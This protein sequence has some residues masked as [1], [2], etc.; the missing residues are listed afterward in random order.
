MFWKGK[1]P[2]SNIQSK[3]RDFRYQLLMKACK[4]NKIK[5]LFLGHHKDD[6]Y[7]NFFIRLI[8]G[9]GLKGLVSLAKGD[10]KLSKDFVILRPL[11]NIEKK[12]LKYISKKVF[13]YYIE[14]PSNKNLDFQRIRLRKLIKEFH[15]EGLNL[16][17]LNL[18]IKN[19]NSANLSIESIVNNNIESN[20]KFINNKCILN[21]NFFCEGNEI[22][23]RS[24]SEVLRRVSGRHYSARGNKISRAIKV[25]ILNAKMKDFTLGGCIIKKIN[26]TLIISRE[27]RD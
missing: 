1:K 11:L 14:D 19:L 12:D 18:T 22:V 10:V 5:N 2:N 6:L 24:F 8:R 17:K 4:K 25:N 20:S 16:N 23:F 3:A 27:K 26:K 15:K 9:S 21:E 7:E 13:N